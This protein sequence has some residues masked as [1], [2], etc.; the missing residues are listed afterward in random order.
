MGTHEFSG[1][2]GDFDGNEIIDL[3]DHAELVDCIANAQGAPP[4]C[5]DSFDFDSNLG[6]DLFDYRVLQLNF[7][8]SE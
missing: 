6:V 5:R 1:C 7:A 2:R 3:I 8:C 4:A